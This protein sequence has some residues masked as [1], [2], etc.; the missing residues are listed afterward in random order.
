ME[1]AYHAYHNGYDL[2]LESSFVMSNDGLF[3]RSVYF[4]YVVDG[5]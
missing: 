5:A 1:V 4:F 2:E 3:E